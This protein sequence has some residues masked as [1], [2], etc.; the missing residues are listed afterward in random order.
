MPPKSLPTSSK[1]PDSSMLMEV[2]SL[3][4]TSIPPCGK[5]ARKRGSNLDL[6]SPDYSAKFALLELTVKKLQW[7][8]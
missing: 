1:P 8:N 5:R 6:L 2:D 4:S 3:S 7:Y